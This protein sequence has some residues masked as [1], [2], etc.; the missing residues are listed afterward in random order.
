MDDLSLKRLRIT[1][2]EVGVF[3]ANESDSDRVTLSENSI[4]G[5]TFAG[6]YIGSKN[7]RWII[8]SNKLF[9]IPVERPWMISLTVFLLLQHDQCWAPG[10]SK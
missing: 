4:F 7:D 3:A 6:I 1:G 10:R 9:G 5:N 2:A 8:D